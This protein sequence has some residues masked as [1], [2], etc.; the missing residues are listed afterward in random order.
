MRPSSAYCARHGQIGLDSGRINSC[1]AMFSAP[2]WSRARGLFR[3]DRRQN[4]EL[5][6]LAAA[7]QR[8]AESG[9]D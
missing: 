5:S 1:L 9:H 4:L 2:R 6:A 7:S 3:D 8:S